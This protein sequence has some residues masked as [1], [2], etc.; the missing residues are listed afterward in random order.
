MIIVQQSYGQVKVEFDGQ[1]SAFANYSPDSYTDILMGGRYL[2]ELNLNWKLKNTNT[3]DFQVAANLFGVQAFHEFNTIWNDTE[4]K[5]YRAWGRYTT[6]QFELRVGLQ[7][8]NFGSANILRPL[9]WFD[10]IDPRDPLKFTNGV[11]AVLARYYFLNNSNIWLWGLYGNENPR[12][13]E[14]LQSQEKI[15]EFGGRIQYP[16]PR[17]EIAFSYHHRVAKYFNPATLSYIMEIPENKFALDAKWDVVIGLWFET[18]YTK[19]SKDALFINHQTLTTFGTDYT[20]G[21]GNGINFLIEHMISTFDDEV[22]EYSNVSNST[23]SIISYP[24]GMYDNISVIN[25][26]SWDMEAYSIYV[27][28]QHQF[29]NFTGYIS[30][31][32]NPDT[33]NTII[34][35]NLK[36]TFSGPGIRL[37]LVFNH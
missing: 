4:I 17:G 19:K 27:N 23:A 35:N 37:M 36:N 2:P 25:S 10:E 33:K 13:Y 31:Y 29:K 6:K 3:I 20:F 15:P 18:S 14:I 28:Y 30:A 22:F 32:Y 34:D 12:G 24:F 21:I 11:Y 1:A 5:P 9:Q 7:K 8:I 26:Y 16:I